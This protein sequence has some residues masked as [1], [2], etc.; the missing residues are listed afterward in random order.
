M[1]SIRSIVVVASVI[2][3]AL[4]APPAEAAATPLPLT[5]G[6]QI[7]IPGSYRA[8]NGVTGCGNG[9]LVDVAVSNVTLDLADHV[10]GGDD[11]NCARAVAV[12]PT[13]SNV[14]IHSGIV[15]DCDNGVFATS[16]GTGITVR[17]MLATSNVNGIVLESDSRA[18][19][20][21]VTGND[22][23]GIDVADSN[24]IS[25]NR[26]SGN[27]V[28]ISASDEN[29]ITGNTIE[30][31]ETGVEANNMNTITENVARGNASGISVAGNNVIRSNVTKGN[32]ASG[33][34]AGEGNRIVANRAH[35]NGADG[36]FVATPTSA[37]L[38][39]DNVANFNGE[40][41]IDAGAGVR[42]L[43][44]NRAKGNGVD[45][46]CDPEELCT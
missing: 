43:G 25:K 5:C 26:V 7:T 6:T 46:Q 23:I 1:R 32:G 4:F 40:Q 17:D 29:Q 39:K 11:V 24:V 35:N 42:G 33:I 28:G 21:T 36:I 37:T 13:V 3:G 16:S 18:T 19:R 8:T 34:G 44:T 31:N 12:A 2:A 22:G 20:N 41:G 45:P 9:V 38:I 10:V 30:G 14:T 27:P 15:R